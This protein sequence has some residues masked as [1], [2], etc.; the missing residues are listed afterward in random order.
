MNK[1]YF[2]CKIIFFIKH[3]TLK[4]FETTISNQWCEKYKGNRMMMMCC[5][6]KWCEG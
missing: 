5:G 2:M 4:F 3:F 6:D 1:K